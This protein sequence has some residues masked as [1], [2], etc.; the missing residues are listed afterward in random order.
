MSKSSINI[1]VKAIAQTTT[2]A[3]L[4]QDQKR[5][6]R[7]FPAS[8]YTQV[9]HKSLRGATNCS[10]LMQILLLANI[11]CAGA[12]STLGTSMQPNTLE[13]RRC[14]KR[15]DV[16]LQM[17]SE[18]CLADNEQNHHKAADALGLLSSA[19]KEVVCKLYPD[20]Q[21]SSPSAFMEDK[22]MEA[23]DILTRFP[24][25]LLRTNIMHTDFLSVLLGVRAHGSVNIKVSISEPENQLSAKGIIKATREAIEY[26]NHRHGKHFKLTIDD[27]VNELHQELYNEELYSL[28]LLNTDLA[29]IVFKDNGKSYCSE[30]SLDENLSEMQTDEK[31]AILGQL[32]G[33]DKDNA[34]IYGSFMRT[35]YDRSFVITASM[36]S[37]DYYKPT[38]RQSSTAAL[39]DHNG[40]NKISSIVRS[41]VYEPRL[42]G[43]KETA[44]KDIFEIQEGKIVVNEPKLITYSER[45][46]KQAH[47]DCMSQL[48]DHFWRTDSK[49]GPTLFN[50]LKRA[51]NWGESLSS[52]M[53][54]HEIVAPDMSQS[55]G[56]L[57]R[58]FVPCEHSVTR[59][60]WE[61]RFKDALVRVVAQE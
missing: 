25:E 21:G 34:G 47:R 57:R 12:V 33:I 37:N 32:Y 23:L 19:E 50:K 45:Q 60:L 58:C 36:L 14:E 13:R 9:G 30:K 26:V 61:S 11:L 4:N 44:C 28:R 10:R 49:N 39:A 15:D 7:Q 38:E 52:P 55:G 56:F 42:T 51:L 43:Q 5:G 54:M 41:F 8:R 6:H 18:Y 31:E 48:R 29:R 20:Y 35:R 1:P 27:S 24:P 17:D 46:D 22:V 16:P 2:T 59:S 3:D 40:L 53:L